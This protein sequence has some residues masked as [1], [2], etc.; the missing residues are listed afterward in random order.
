MAS[1]TTETHVKTDGGTETTKTSQSESGDE[2]T[3]TNVTVEKKTATTEA[4]E[5]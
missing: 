5:I 4:N 3:E 2:A 1:E